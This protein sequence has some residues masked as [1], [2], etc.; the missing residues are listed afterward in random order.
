[1]SDGGRDWMEPTQHEAHL[2]AWYGSPAPSARADEA[3]EA[4]ATTDTS[5]ARVTTVA[6]R[7]ELT[8]RT[9]SETAESDVSTMPPD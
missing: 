3:N 2:D 5:A 1:M 8:D 4:M 9:G 7:T 6:R